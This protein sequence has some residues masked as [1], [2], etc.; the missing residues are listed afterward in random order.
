MNGKGLGCKVQRIS[1]KKRESLWKTNQVIHSFILQACNANKLEVQ[2]SLILTNENSCSQIKD[3]LHHQLSDQIILEEFLIKFHQFRIKPLTNYSISVF[4]QF[5]TLI[6]ENKFE[7][8]ESQSKILPVYFILGKWKRIKEILEY[9]RAT[10]HP[11]FMCWN[12]WNE[13]FVNGKSK[14]R[15]QGRT[16]YEKLGNFYAVLTS[17]AWGYSDKLVYFVKSGEFGQLEQILLADIG[18]VYNDKADDRENV[19]ILKENLEG[20]YKKLAFCRILYHYFNY[21]L[22]E[23]AHMFC[24]YVKNRFTGEIKDL[25]EGIF[26]KICGKLKIVQVLQSSSNLLENYHFLRASIKYN[27]NVP[28]D[29]IVSSCNIIET[30]LLAYKFYACMFDVKVTFR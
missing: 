8:F 13:L 12:M 21:N 20:T 27:L 10:K 24:V 1:R 4:S 16:V 17:K 26:M 30:T 11:L 22:L 15:C 9:L 19:G 25:A 29:K 18:L 6:K 7:D 5:F 14:I 3:L 28:A 23:T 2:W